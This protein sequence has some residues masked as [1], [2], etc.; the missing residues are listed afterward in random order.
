MDSATDLFNYHDTMK[1]FS[2]LD[3]VLIAHVQE[4]R[5]NIN[6]HQLQCSKTERFSIEE[7]HDIYQGIVNAGF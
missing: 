7:F 1:V 6:I 5:G 3:I 4:P 2:S